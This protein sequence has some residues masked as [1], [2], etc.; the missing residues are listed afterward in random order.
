LANNGEHRLL[1]T[2]TETISEGLA[3]IPKDT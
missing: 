3:N 1:I 2:E